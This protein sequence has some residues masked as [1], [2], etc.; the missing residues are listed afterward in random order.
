MQCLAVAALRHLSLN[1]RIK[2][3]IVEEGALQPLIAAGTT[4]NNIDLQ[5]Q[6]SGTM[7]NLTENAR[8]QVTIVEA[9]GLQCSVSLVAQGQDKVFESDAS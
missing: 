8:N 5:Q 9:G 6:I 4:T 7:A 3:K 1:D 2:R